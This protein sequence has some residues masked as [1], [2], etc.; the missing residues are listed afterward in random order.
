MQILA[1]LREAD[2]DTPEWA[3][4]LDALTSRV[5]IQIALRDAA[6]ARDEEAKAERTARRDKW[7]SWS[8][9]ALRTRAGPVYR[10]VKEGS[11][12]PVLPPAPTNPP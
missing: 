5:Q 4:K 8:A 9:H 10:W 6:Q 11:K 12:V 2:K 7:H 1:A 3:E